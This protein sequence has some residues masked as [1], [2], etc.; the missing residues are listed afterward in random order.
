MSFPCAARSNPKRDVSLQEKA[1]VSPNG[2]EK[3]PIRRK[4]FWAHLLS[5]AFSLQGKGEERPALRIL[6]APHL[7]VSEGGKKGYL[8]FPEKASTQ[9]GGNPR[10]TL[11]EGVLYYE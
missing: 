3:S 10:S 8:I 6:P 9:E 5:G 11:R 1:V 2:K 7:K 4:G